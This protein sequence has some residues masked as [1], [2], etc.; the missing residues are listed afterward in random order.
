MKKAL[1]TGIAGQDGSYLAELLLSKGYK[2]YGMERAAYQKSRTNLELIENDIEFVTGDLTDQNTLAEIIETTQPDEVYNLAAHSFVKGSWDQPEI[3]SN[4]NGLGALRLLEVIKMINPKIKFYQASSSEMF[5]RT[6]YAP[7]NE[8]TPFYPCTPYGIAK[9]YAYWTTV[10]YRETYDLFACSGILYNH[11]SPRRGMEFVTRKITDGV[12]RI[13]LGLQDKLYLGNL[14]A[15]RDWGYAPEFVDAIW[16]MMQQEQAQDFV[17]GT[18]EAHTV[19]EFVAEAFSIVDL[20]WE[21]YVVID[22]KFVRHSDVGLLV[23]DPSKAR[24]VLGWQTK[25]K[26][27]EL[28]KIM[29]EADI[30]RLQTLKKTASFTKNN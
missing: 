29:V 11:E 24:D 18:G 1:I 30:D 25:V 4:V 16:R 13:K 8:K 19:K 14:D 23:A 3:Y 28:V 2:I 21:E 10:N 27:S 17:I 7:Q 6:K 22:Q 5:G 20:N 26:F 15:K 12:A 9:M